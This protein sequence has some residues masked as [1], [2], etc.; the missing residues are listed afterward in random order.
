VGRVRELTFLQELFAQVEAGQ[1]QVVGIVGEPGIGKSRLLA[2]FRHRLRG[3]RLTYLT[4]GCRSYGQSTP[5]LPV[6]TLLRTHR[7]IAAT[8]APADMTVKIHRRL[9]EVGM[10]PEAWAPYLL[11]LLE[12]AT[13]PDLLATVSPQE[14]RARTTEALVQLALHGALQMPLVLE[15]ENLH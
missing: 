14:M 8:D 15:V 12:V 10:A 4:G 13:D 7:D 11:W 6:R 2:E 3:R 1:G 5:Y 9:T